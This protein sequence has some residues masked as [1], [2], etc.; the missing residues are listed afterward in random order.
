MKHLFF[1]VIVLLLSKAD[2][3]SQP[4]F[5][6][7]IEFTTQTDIDNFATSNPNCTEIIGYVRISGDEIY[8]LEGLKQLTKIQG[9]FHIQAS[10]NLETLNG[11]D[12][13]FSVGKLIIDLNE[14]LIDLTALSNL[15]YTGELWIGYNEKLTTLNGLNNCDSMSFISISNNPELVDISSLNNVNPNTI[16]NLAIINNSSL[17]ECAIDCVCDFLKNSPSGY[18]SIYNNNDGCYSSNQVI[19]DC[20]SSVVN[21]K[22]DI[23]CFKFFPNPMANELFIINESNRHIDQVLVYNHLGQIVLKQKKALSK[24]NVSMLEKG[25]YFIELISENR[26]YRTKLIKK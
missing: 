22:N 3:I 17:S 23:P 5:P 21:A 13:L 12:S 9:N 24:I 15:T 25:M 7:G 14:N 19:E 10:S 1:I 2:L 11:L 20:E 18:Y 26:I 16:T 6:N 4:C 8:N